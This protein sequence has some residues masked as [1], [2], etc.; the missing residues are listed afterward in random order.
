MWISVAE[1]ACENK[2]RSRADLATLERIEGGYCVS[3]D[4]SRRREMMTDGRGLKVV[5]VEPVQ[6]DESTRFSS[7]P[8]RRTV[9][10][11]AAPCGARR[12]PSG[13][14]KRVRSGHAGADGGRR[15]A[16]AGASE[17]ARE[18]RGACKR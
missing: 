12:L 1:S 4:A 18:R 15:V 17:A 7:S 10:R 9:V 5:F 13:A 2:L 8:Q 14:R 16:R 11:W 6:V 3:I